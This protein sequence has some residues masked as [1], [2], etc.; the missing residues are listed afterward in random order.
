MCLDLVE[1]LQTITILSK[2]QH[3]VMPKNYKVVNNMMDS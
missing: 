2:K 3:P 1:K